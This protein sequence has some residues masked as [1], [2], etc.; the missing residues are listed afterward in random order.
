VGG[1]DLM[2]RGVTKYRKR[3]S[4]VQRNATRPA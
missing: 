4:S 2:G 1:A 3:R